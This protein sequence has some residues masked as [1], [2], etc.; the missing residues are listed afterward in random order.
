MA[1]TI[2]IFISY[3]DKDHGY[4]EDLESQL[5]P[6]IEKYSIT[7]WHKQKVIP[8]QEHQQEVDKHLKAARI[9]LLLVSSSYLASKYLY[10]HEV[11]RAIEYK[12]AGT[13]EVIPVLLRL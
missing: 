8:G 3:A 1:D 4:V 10:T 5:A 9:I 7:I 2:E 12:K 13:A 6:M 11:Q